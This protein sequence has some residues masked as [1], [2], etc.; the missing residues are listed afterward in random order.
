[1]IRS[2]RLSQIGRIMR[3]VK[4]EICLYEDEGVSRKEFDSIINEKVKEL[5]KQLNTKRGSIVDKMTRQ[6]D[7]IRMA[8]FKNELWD[9]FI[10]KAPAEK[11]VLGTR[12]LQNSTRKDSKQSIKNMLTSVKYH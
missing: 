11:T 2:E 8:E 1:M 12:I 6:L 9:F 10:D 4:E 7:N 3:E 5:S